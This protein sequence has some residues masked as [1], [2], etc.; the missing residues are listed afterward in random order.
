[1]YI[2]RIEPADAGQFTVRAENIAG[3]ARSTADLV[4]RPKGTK[5]GQYYHVTKV[6]QE[7]QEIGLEVNKDSKYGEQAV[8]S[9]FSQPAIKAPRI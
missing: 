5:P 6:T 3:E 9:T 2:P 1:M 8:G 7:K 4:V